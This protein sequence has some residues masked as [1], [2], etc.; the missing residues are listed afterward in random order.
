MKFIENQGYTTLV[1]DELPPYF[2]VCTVLYLNHPL[3]LKKSN[4]F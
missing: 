3:K 2:T 1:K 4:K